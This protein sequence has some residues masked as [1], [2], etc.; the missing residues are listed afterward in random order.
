MGV[1]LRG[2]TFGRSGFIRGVEFISGVTFV[3]GGFMRG[4]PWWEWLYK[5][6]D[7]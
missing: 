5:R 6:G 2:V 7:I 3:G 1:D 4:D